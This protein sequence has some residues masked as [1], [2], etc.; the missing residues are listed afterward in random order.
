MESTGVHLTVKGVVQG[1]GFRWF[2]NRAANRLELS[3]WV[4]N[5]P[6]GSVEI[7]AYGDRGSIEGLISEIKVGPSFS[8]VSDVRVNWKEPDSSQDGFE[9]I[10]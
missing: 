3:G 8:R 7:E 2:V 5:Q 10:F 6:D 1:V 4:R 9:V